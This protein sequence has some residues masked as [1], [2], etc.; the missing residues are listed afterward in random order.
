MD[1]VKEEETAEVMPEEAAV[2]VKVPPVLSCRPVKEAVPKEVEAVRV[3]DTVQAGAK[4]RVMLKVLRALS[5]LL[6]RLS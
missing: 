2:I 1:T 6:R 4:E 5:I 3:P